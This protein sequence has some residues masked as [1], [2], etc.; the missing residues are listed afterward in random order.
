MIG[1]LS[2]ILIEKKPPTLAINVNGVTYELDAPMSTFY[3]LPEKNQSITVY[4][5]LLVREDAHLL[6]GFWTEEERAMFRHLVKVNGVGARTALSVLSGISAGDLYQIVRD[7]DAQRLIAVPGIGKKTAERMLLELS[8]R[9][10]AFSGGD[11]VVDGSNKGDAVHALLA[12]GY[13]EKEVMA[14]LKTVDENLTVSE[15]V[16]EALQ[17]LS[18]SF[19]SKT[20]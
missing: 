19:L 17:L 8:D 12:L 16:K 3:K 5:H 11:E 13:S 1:R 2:G 4:T 20:Q 6:F 7:K 14:V 9:L 18:K 10:P 15:L